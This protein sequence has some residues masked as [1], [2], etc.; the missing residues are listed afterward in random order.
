MAENSPSKEKGVAVPDFMVDVS[1]LPALDTIASP[2]IIQRIKDADIDKD[3]RLSVSELVQLVQSEQRALADRRLLRNFLIAIVLAVL[4]LVAALV[5]AVFGIVKLTD[6]VDDSNGVLVSAKTGSVM[7]T[8]KATELVVLS[9]LYAKASNTSGSTNPVSIAQQMEVVVVPHDEVE[10]G[11]TVHRVASIR[12]YPSEQL[13]I[14]V[15]VDG[16]VI[17]VDSSGLRYLRDPLLDLIPELS[18]ASLT[19]NASSSGRRRVLS[20]VGQSGGFGMR[21]RTQVVYHF[22]GDYDDE[23]FEEYLEATRRCCF[24]S[25]L[26]AKFDGCYEQSNCLQYKDRI[27][28]NPLVDY[29]FCVDRCYRKHCALPKKS[30]DETEREFLSTDC[31]EFMLG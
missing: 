8:G 15:S 31:R 2:A 12:S 1:N 7:A 18:S 14:I 9:Q 11:F 24:E 6:E 13:A 3:G 17:Q 23:E 5:G 30:Y 22:D 19:T 20:E 27:S 26:L 16:T 4:I 10:G 21:V 29:E 28:H 25:E